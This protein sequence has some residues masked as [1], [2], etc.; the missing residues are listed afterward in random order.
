MESVQAV[1]VHSF[2]KQISLHRMSFAFA[3]F[4]LTLLREFMCKD[5]TYSFRKY[6]IDGSLKI[7]LMERPESTFAMISCIHQIQDN[8]AYM[9]MLQEYIVIYISDNGTK[10][11]SRSDTVQ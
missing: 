9:L 5:E 2:Q 10:E 3:I 8:T 11:V 1:A 6:D 4:D 7:S